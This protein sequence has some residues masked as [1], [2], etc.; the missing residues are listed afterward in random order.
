[1]TNEQVKFITLLAGGGFCPLLISFL[2]NYMDLDQVLQNIQPDCKIC[3]PSLWHF[4][5]IHER[6]FWKK[7]IL[8]QSVDNKKTCKIIVKAWKELKRSIVVRFGHAS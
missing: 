8:K 4:D 2:N 6:L 1:M 3:E 7:V 5:G